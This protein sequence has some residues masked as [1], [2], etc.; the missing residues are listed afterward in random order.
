VPAG[1][2]LQPLAVP[3][4]GR[5]GPAIGGHATRIGQVLDVRN[6]GSPDGFYLV[7]SDGVSPV[8]QTQA[9]LALTDPATAGAYPGASPAPVV[10][11]TAMIASVP[12]SRAALPDGRGVPVT[13]PA[14]DSPAPPQAPCVDYRGA[15]RAPAIVFA[16]PPA[17]TPPAVGSLGVTATPEVANRITVMP[18]SGALVRPEAAPGVAGD[19]EFLVTGLGVKFPVPSAAA[20]AALGYQAS[21]AQS[22]PATLLALLPTGPALD[23]APLQGAAPGVIATSPP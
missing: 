14:A 23:L 18:G 3:G 15:A 2:D 13:P 10:V 16:A 20:V 6:V 17:G 12:L 7:E 1:P 22:L 5:Q 21:T 9:A 4:L 8:T 19:S 11:S